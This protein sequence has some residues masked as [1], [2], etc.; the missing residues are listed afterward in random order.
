M[1]GDR[2]SE[3]I[4][5]DEILRNVVQWFRENDVNEYR[6]YF[7]NNEQMFLELKYLAFN[8]GPMIYDGLFKDFFTSLE[9]KIALMKR[10]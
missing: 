1:S 9:A 7:L 3:I 10:E 4:K 6:A 5:L 2:V 8:L